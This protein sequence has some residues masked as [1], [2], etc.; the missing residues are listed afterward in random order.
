MHAAHWDIFCSVVDNFGDIGVSWRLARQLRKEHGLRV[1]LWVDDPVSFGLLEPRLQPGLPHQTLEGVDILHWTPAAPA[2]AVPGDVVVEAFGCA[3][4]EAFEQRMAERQ[5]RPVWINLDYLSA[6]A[7]VEGV[8]KLGSPHPRL[9]LQS[10]F[11]SPGFTPATGG[12][13]R[14]ADLAGER[15]AFQADTT[16]QTGFWQ[17]HTGTTPPEGALKVSLFAYENAALPG[18]LD[19]WAAGPQP[20]FCAVPVGR[21]L[22]GVKHWADDDGL[23]AGSIVRRGALTLAVLPFLHHADYDRLLWACDLNFVRGEDSFVRAQ[24]ARRPLVWH[25]YPQREGAH[26]VKLEAFLQ[27]YV[28]GLEPSAALALRSFWSGWN[29]DTDSTLPP[30]PALLDALPALTRHAAGWEAALV[31]RPDLARQL[32]DFCNSLLK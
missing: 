28:T 32:A 15:D 31:T 21:V 13:L 17:Q 3:L 10:H 18:L 30:W 6:E 23:A 29:G 11:F 8:H 7:W 4:G 2:G 20:V 9:P 16:A 1:R 27:R 19:L 22:A 25:I 12:L 26:L 14:E 24:W 5:P